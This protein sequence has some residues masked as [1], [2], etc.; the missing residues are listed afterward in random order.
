MFQED[1]GMTTMVC[2]STWTPTWRLWGVAVLGDKNK[3]WKLPGGRVELDCQSAIGRANADAQAP[4]PVVAPGA[5]PPCREASCMTPVVDV[6]RDDE[7]QPKK[8]TKSRNHHIRW[9]TRRMG[10]PCKTETWM[11]T[12][13]LA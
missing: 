5:V 8:K 12:Q 4:A 2:L 7:G 9:V 11:M 10:H 3:I 1:N 6:D 13:Q